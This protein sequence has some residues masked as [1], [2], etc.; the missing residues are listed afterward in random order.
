MHWILA[1]FAGIGLKP[2]TYKLKAWGGLLYA[3]AYPS[4]GLTEEDVKSLPFEALSTY[5]RSSTPGKWDNRYFIYRRPPSRLLAREFSSIK[6]THHR[7][8]SS[9]DD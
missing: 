4:L 5:G 8:S 3:P 6:L 9:I 7:I 1:A 2:G